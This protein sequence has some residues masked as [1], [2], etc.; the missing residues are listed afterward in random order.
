MR[1]NHLRELLKADKPSIGT[2]IHTT[3]PTV[4]ELI[5]YAGGFDYVEFLAEYAPYDLYALDNMGRALELANLTGMI[6]LEQEPRLYWAAKATQAGFQA[7]L[8]ADVRTVEDAQRC[9]QAVRAETPATRGLHGVAMT[10]DVGIL[11]EGA[12]PAFVQS[13]EDAVVALM[14]EKKSAVDNLEAIL[15][16]PGI[17]MLQF[18]PADFSLSSGLVGQRDNPAIL[19]A[20]EYMVKTALKKGI[21]PRVEIR[22][23]AQAERWMKLGVKHF[24]M[25][26]DVS[27]LFNWFKTQGGALRELMQE[28]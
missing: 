1:K 21:A 19:E 16:V 8:F 22:E 10:R 20:Q 14:I 12:S 17:D 9:V 4:I 15:S 26:W 28:K 13:L 2:H 11:L 27:I 24:C 5:G 3:W 18:G 23:P 25:G 6:K 7:V